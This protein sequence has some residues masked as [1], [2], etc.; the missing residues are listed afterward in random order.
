MPLKR[1]VAANRTCRAATKAGGQCAAPE[2]AAAPCARSTRTPTERVNSVAI[3]RDAR[4]PAL[5]APTTDATVFHAQQADE[6]TTVF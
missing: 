4:G 5:P 6:S 1:Q 3:T 2:F